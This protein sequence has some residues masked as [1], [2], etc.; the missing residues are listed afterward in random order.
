[1]TMTDARDAKMEPFVVGFMTT[2]Q[3]SLGWRKPTLR[4]IVKIQGVDP[5]IFSTKK[6]LRSTE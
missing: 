6:L 2:V 4:F 5:R 1:M 3:S